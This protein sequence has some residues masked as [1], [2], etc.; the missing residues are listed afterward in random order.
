MTNR[1]ISFG[2]AILFLCLIPACSSLNVD[3]NPVEQKAV[4]KFFKEDRD[5]KKRMD[6]AI[7]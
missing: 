4:H 3:L 1:T 2:G 7:F 6:E 5:E